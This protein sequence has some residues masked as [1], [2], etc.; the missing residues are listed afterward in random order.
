MKTLLALIIVASLSAC[1]T[2]AGVGQDIKSS[3]EWT[4]EKLGNKL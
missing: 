1:S 2:V 4:K 3:A